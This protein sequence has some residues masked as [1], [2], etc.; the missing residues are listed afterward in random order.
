MTQNELG[1]KF[2]LGGFQNDEKSYLNS[3]RWNWA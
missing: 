1:K 2:N 3:R